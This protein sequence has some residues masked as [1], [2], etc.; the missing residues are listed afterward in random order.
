MTSET[1]DIRL[2]D[3]DR[4]DLP[5]LLAEMFA[6]LDIDW[7]IAPVLKVEISRPGGFEVGFDGEAETAY[8]VIIA[9]EADSSD[10]RIGIAW[11]W[12]DKVHW[13]DVHINECRDDIIEAVNDW[14]EDD[15]KWVNRT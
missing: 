5:S 12:A 10:G 4:T 8:S 11:G 1:R 13:G 15:V 14:L 2:S 7:D 9:D 6:G 3:I